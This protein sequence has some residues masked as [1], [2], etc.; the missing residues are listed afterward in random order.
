M[1]HDP[2]LVDPEKD[3]TTETPNSP[4]PTPAPSPDPEQDAPPV[5]D[6]AASEPSGEDQE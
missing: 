3:E 6:E 1:E 4:V 5:P 2:N